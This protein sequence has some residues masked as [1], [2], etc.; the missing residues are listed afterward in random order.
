MAR[1]IAYDCA[2][3]LDMARAAEDAEART[4]AARRGAFLTPIAKAY[5]T[6]TGIEVANLCIQVHGGTGYCEDA[7]VAQYA[8]DVRITAIY[9]GTNGVQA[10]DLVGRKLTGDGGETAMALIAGAEAT[11]AAARD[12]GLTAEADALAAAKSK[13]EGVTRWMLGSDDRDRAAGSTPYL[14][15][16]ATVLGGHYLLAAATEGGVEER[17]LA[18]FW[19]AQMLP[20]AHAEAQAV[21]AGADQ[22]YAL[23]AATLTASA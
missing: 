1:A 6:E 8:R 18:A 17:A 7:G 3:A 10:M 20:R 4:A 2:F 16:L 22:L 14:R 19:C 11:I 13:I 12:A 5:G 9:E 23:D 15:L 21:C